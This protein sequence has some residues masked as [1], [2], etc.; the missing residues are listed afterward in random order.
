[1]KKIFWCQ[2]KLAAKFP[3]F[4]RL[5]G[6]PMPPLQRRR[7]KN[8]EARGGLRAEASGPKYNKRQIHSTTFGEQNGPYCSH[9][10]GSSSLQARGSVRDF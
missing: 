3:E 10:E 9:A 8:S 2:L 6:P 7:S 4:C 1:M 5:V